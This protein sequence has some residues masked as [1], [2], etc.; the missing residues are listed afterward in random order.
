[1]W[2]AS[3]EGYTPAAIDMDA[4]GAIDVSPSSR[5]W[6]SAVWD[7]STQHVQVARLGERLSSMHTLNCHSAAIALNDVVFRPLSRTRQGK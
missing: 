5:H 7:Y 3:S 4:Q 2:V 1:M 6:L